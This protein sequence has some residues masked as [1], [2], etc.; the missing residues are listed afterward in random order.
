METINQLVV[1]AA[2]SD[3][4]PA[5]VLLEKVCCNA[6]GYSILNSVEKREDLV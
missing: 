5:E 6:D 4:Y 3:L 1:K 2:L